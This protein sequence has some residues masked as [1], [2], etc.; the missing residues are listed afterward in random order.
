MLVS[1]IVL[2]CVGCAS[3]HKTVSFNSATKADTS[4][5]V[6]TAQ[7]GVGQTT[8]IVEKL[9]TAKTVIDSVNAVDSN[10]VAEVIT[11]I[12]TVKT[13]TFGTTERTER[14]VIE[15]QGK[16]VS[17]NMYV[18]QLSIFTD[19]LSLVQH[20]VDSLIS[21]LELKYRSEYSD[22]VSVMETVVKDSKVNDFL[23]DFL[24][25]FLLLLKVVAV[26]VVVAVGLWLWRKFREFN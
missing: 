22:T 24:N 11:E 6:R 12:I 17:N 16:S 25:G 10:I 21:L 18:S 4:L 14:R 3:S 15:R 8:T 19:S 2:L 26:A 13:D 23:A 1:C 9:R 7:G 20:R 5:M